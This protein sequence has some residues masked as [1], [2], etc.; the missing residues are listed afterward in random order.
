M[1]TKNTGGHKDGFSANSPEKKLYL[2]VVLLCGCQKTF[3]HPQK[4][5]LFPLPDQLVSANSHMQYWAVEG[6]HHVIIHTALGENNELIMTFAPVQGTD[7][8]IDKKLLKFGSSLRCR[9]YS[10]STP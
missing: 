2:V 4:M 8:N 5:M 1:V 9:I 10:P 3:Q 6:C 7:Y